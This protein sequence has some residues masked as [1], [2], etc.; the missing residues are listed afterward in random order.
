MGQK[1]KT[2]YWT[3]HSM[4]THSNLQNKFP[5]DRTKKQGK[6]EDGK[7]KEKRSNLSCMQ[8]K[9]LQIS[10]NLFESF[11]QNKR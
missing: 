8:E 11:F 10:L 3:G 1:V 5:N 4:I 9:R 7:K 6:H 2:M